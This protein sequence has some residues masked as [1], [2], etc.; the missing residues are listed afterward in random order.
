MTVGFFLPFLLTQQQQQQGLFLF[1]QEF[2]YYVQLASSSSLCWLSKYKFQNLVVSEF[3]DLVNVK[4]L[5]PRL[6]K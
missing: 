4:A 3:R 1:I 5:Q 6:K 2:V